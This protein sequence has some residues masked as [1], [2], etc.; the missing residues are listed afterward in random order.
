MNAPLHLSFIIPTRSRSPRLLYCIEV[1]RLHADP[2][3]MSVRLK[4]RNKNSSSR[5][6][7]HRPSPFIV[8]TPG[9][10]LFR[11]PQPSATSRFF[12]FVPRATVFQLSFHATTP[13]PFHFPL[14]LYPVEPVDIISISYIR[15]LLYYIIR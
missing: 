7:H 11:C 9:T 8:V 10:Y 6:A 4:S 15:Y 3:T 1:N 2:G 14:L 12:S 5:A 13:L